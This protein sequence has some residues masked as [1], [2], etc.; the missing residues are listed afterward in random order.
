MKKIVCH[1]SRPEYAA[2]A[3]PDWFFISTRVLSLLEKGDLLIVQDLPE[4][5]T[6]V[7]FWKKTTSVQFDVIAVPAENYAGDVDLVHKK[8]VLGEIA[9]WAGNQNDRVVIHPYSRTRELSQ[10]TSAFADS[11]IFVETA[12][13]V[14]RFLSK[15]IFYGQEAQEIFSDIL[16]PSGALCNTTNDLICAQKKLGGEIFVKPAIS[17]DGEGG[18]HAC[19]LELLSNY[20][21]PLG[22]V[23]MQQ[24][25]DCAHTVSV[26]YCGGELYGGVV[27][28]IMS[29]T[30]F[31]GCQFPSSAPIAFQES[32]CEQA[33]RL[34]L[35]M[36]PQAWGGFDF[37]GRI[38]P[39]LVDINPRF[40][41]ALPGKIFQQKFWPSKP[42]IACELSS[43][44]TQSV[45]EMWGVLSSAKTQF[46][47][48]GAAGIFPLAYAPNVHAQFI[49]CGQS[50]SA[51][52]K[53]KEQCEK[54]L[55]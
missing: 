13:F 22:P 14:E 5:T 50:I 39:Y 40:T 15:E 37:L 24:E 31:V 29:G 9:K 33:Q 27:D 49:F 2:D 17:S 28:Q 43:V 34:L 41:G 26:Q 51:C 1:F 32:V 10:W 36:K 20:D 11:E 44:P 7:D 16:I 47:F 25:I 18:F 35:R 3:I 4:I 12:D 8:D 52:K 53:L 23:V 6:F 42:F 48:D 46:S 45:E 55:F 19:S 38:E 54:L 21:F 30:Q